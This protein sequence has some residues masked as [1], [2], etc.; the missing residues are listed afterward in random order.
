MKLFFLDVVNEPSF[1]DNPKN[2]TLLVILSVAAIAAITGIFIW[3][4]KRKTAK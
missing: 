4:K 2:I 1:T 3:R